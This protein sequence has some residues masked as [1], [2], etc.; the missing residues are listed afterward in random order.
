MKPRDRF[1]TVAFVMFAA[2]A[3]IA[4]RPAKAASTASDNACNSPYKG[5]SWS[6]GQ[7]GGTRLA[8]GHCFRRAAEHRASSPPAPRTPGI[9][10]PAA[11]ELAPVAANPG[12][13]LRAA[14]PLP[15]PQDV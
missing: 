1:V 12:G 15:T 4:I 8:H 11:V 10:V 3:L 2:T 14:G 5:T 6:P 13:S 7:N 9:V